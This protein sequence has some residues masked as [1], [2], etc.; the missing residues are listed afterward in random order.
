MSGAVRLRR[1]ISHLEAPWND[2]AVGLS[3]STDAWVLI[4]AV[5]SRE[6]LKLK[7]QKNS[8]DTQTR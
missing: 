3:I 2:E 5:P 7:F 1:D 8:L 4:P 6:S